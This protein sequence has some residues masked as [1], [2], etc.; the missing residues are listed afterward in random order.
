MFIIFT[1]TICLFL[2]FS[3]SAFC[4]TSF[5][6]GKDATVDG[7]VIATHNEDLEG[8]T[9]QVVEVVPRRNYEKGSFIIL[10]SGLKVPQVEITYKYIQ[11]NS[12]YNHLVNARD[13]YSA[14]NPNIINEWQVFTGD[15]ANIARDE[16]HKEYPDKGI[17]TAELRRLVAE[18]ATTAREGVEIMGRLVEKYGF[19]KGGGGGMMYLIADP[20]EGWWVEVYVGKHWAAIRCPDNAILLRA[21]AGRIGR[22]NLN[23]TKN[24]LGSK[25]LVSYA[26]EKRWY[27][28][29]TDGE[30]NY[31]KVYGNYEN[32]TDKYNKQREMMSINYFAPSKSLKSMNEELPEHMVIIP[33]KK[34]SKE[35]AMAFQRWHYEGTKFDTSNCYNLGSP[36]FTS[37]EVICNSHTQTS[38]VAQLRNWLPNEIGGCLWL[39]QGSPCTSVFVPW[40]VG[41]TDTPD[42][43]QDA[44]DKYDDRKAFW[45]FK[46]I[47][48]LVNTN[49]KE[50]FKIIKP[51]WEAQEKE[52]FAI[53]SVIEKNALELY[54]KEEK[55]ANTFLTNYSG[56]WAL[57]AYYKLKSLKDKCLTKLAEKNN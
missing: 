13:P 49:Y 44:I 20:N 3:N 12:N 21:N 10:E 45:C 7:S 50:L 54:N 4:C 32:Q 41:I 31:S 47:G 25:S 1:L 26:K 52:E 19:A 18:R 22:I 5:I 33:D 14:D 6:A 48:I 53:Q 38:A 51:V 42:L 23:D 43:Y 46:E 35:D 39:T 15:N 40:Y 34:I 27:N 16:L 36:H 37:E 8:D 9:A 17:S 30:F 56:S 24:F 57:S 29:A 28:P 11:F 2:F 55:H